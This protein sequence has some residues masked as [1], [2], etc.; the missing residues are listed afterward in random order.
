[1]ITAAILV[2]AVVLLPIA[3]VLAPLAIAALLV[4][5]AG[6]GETGVTRPQPLR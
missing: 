6:S 3:L 1:M 4:A 5:V 2:A